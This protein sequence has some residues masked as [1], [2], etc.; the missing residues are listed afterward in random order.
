MRAINALFLATAVMLIMATVGAYQDAKQLVESHVWIQDH[1]TMALAIDL[2]RSQLINARIEQAKYCLTGDRSFL[3]SAG[4]FVD[5]AKHFAGMYKGAPSL[6]WSEP[7]VAKRV[8]VMRSKIEQQIAARHAAGVAAATTYGDEVARR[9]L[10]ESLLANDDE[11]IHRLLVAFRHQQG[12]I[13]RAKGAEFETQIQRTLSNGAFVLVLLGAVILLAVSQKYIKARRRAEETVFLSEQRIRAVV[14]NMLDGLLAIDSNGQIR[15]VNSTA[16]TLL[17]AQNADL[18][19]TD[20]SRFVNKLQAAASGEQ[21]RLTEC[22]ASRLDGTS[23]EAE[24]AVSP[25][26]ITIRDIT[27]RK[28]AEKWR[29]DFVST[30]GTDLFA[31]LSVVRTNL[32]SMR[33]TEAAISPQLSHVLEIA[34]RNADRLL[35]L[36]TDLSDLDQLETGKLQVNPV[37]TPLQQI[38]DRSIESVRALSEQ[39]KIGINVDV[40]DMQVLADPNRIVQVLVNLLSNAIKFSPAD[41]EI[42]LSAET[43]GDVVTVTVSDN[44]RGISA[45]AREIIFERYK[46]AESADAKKGTGLGLPICKMIVEQHGGAIGVDSVV[47]SGSKFWFTLRSIVSMLI[48]VF[49]LQPFGVQAQVLQL[50][51]QGIS[52]AQ[53]EKAPGATPC[54]VWMQPEGPKKGVLVAVHG[55]GLHKGCYAQFADRM[56]KLGWAVYAVD[57][58]GFGNFLTMPKGA[59]HVDFEG[60]MRDVGDA[61]DLVHREHPGM[62]V[63]LVGE[64]MGGGI[65]FQAGSRYADKVNGVISACPATKRLHTLSAAARVAANLLGGKSSMDIRPILV[66]HSTKKQDL[67]DEWLKDEQARFELAPVELIQFQLFMDKNVKAANEMK[68]TPVVILQGTLDDLV[69]GS[70]QEMLLSHIPH[71]DKL[72]IYVD[73]AEHLILEEGQFNDAVIATVSDWLDSHLPKR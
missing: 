54:M 26:L 62:P 58:R 1:V 29:R 41:S 35:D 14:D 70:S 34:E 66:E 32:Y 27:E 10:R 21:S 22:T 28:L 67:R 40:P 68:K 56:T 47:G 33:M 18:A 7:D 23:F 72:L 48:I 38:C 51:Q 60:C 57:V 15:S 39:K 64:S 30:I 61:I 8:Q 16:R 31:P 50:D 45:D 42:K 24:V 2:V 63:F 43:V 71:E 20:I 73:Q 37:P 4:R 17:A 13:I 36:I 25:N 11:Q 52:T 9:K 69:K 19:G 12:Q 6:S 59:R 65:A 53:E 3:E 5:S 55:L 46:Q 49:A 44:G